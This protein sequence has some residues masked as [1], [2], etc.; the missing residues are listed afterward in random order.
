MSI[1]LLSP[2]VFNKIAAGEVVENP[3]SVVK[4]LVENALDANADRVKVIVREAGKK[5]ITVEDNGDGI[6]S[7]EVVLAFSKHATSKIS[8]VDDLEKI[9]TLGFR[10]EA[11]ASIASVSRTTLLTCTQESPSALKVVM[12]SGK[13]TEKKEEARSRG[14]TVKVEDLFKSVPARL[15][16]LKTDPTEIRHIKQALLKILLAHPGLYAELVVDGKQAFL[17]PAVND[18]YERIIQIYGQDLKDILERSEVSSERCSLLAW[19]GN[20]SFAKRNRNYQFFFLNGRAVDVNFFAPLVRQIYDQLLVPGKHGILF[21]YLTVHPEDVD[22]NVHPAKREVRFKDTKFYFEFI[23]RAVRNSLLSA[24]RRIPSGPIS[25]HGTDSSYQ[26]EI[27]EMTTRRARQAE[28]DYK[29]HVDQSINR[30]M[31]NNPSGGENLFDHSV[32]SYGREGLHQEFLQ[33]G[34]GSFKNQALQ[35]LLDH[36]AVILGQ[37]FQTYLL[38]E[39][40]NN[41]LMIDQHAAHERVVYERLKKEMASGRGQAQHLLIP[42]DVELDPSASDRVRQNFGLLETIGYA[43]EEFGQN[44]FLIR[45][46]PAFLRRGNDREVFSEIVDLLTDPESMKLNES[47]LTDRMLKRMACR[48]ALKAGDPQS[49]EDLQALLDQILKLDNIL[50]CPH[51][52]PFVV[53]FGKNDLEKYFVRRV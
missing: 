45:S 42:F 48:T 7:S 43:L 5:E 53:K 9:H 4:E 13:E 40:G 30:Y 46:V 41:F 52:R 12:D 51:G 10:G 25:L 36:D 3:A 33:K 38:L 39:S 37:L 17:Y 6:P 2:E 23:H 35:D 8:Q 27:S 31:E 20:P 24:G 44:A 19:A 22:V 26:E 18:E 32:I 16:F 14:T 50:T 34:K 21:L 49:L 28:A 29:E 11:L 47:D 1:K 15:K